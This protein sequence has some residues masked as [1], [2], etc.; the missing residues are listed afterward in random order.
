MEA[1]PFR[2]IEKVSPPLKGSFPLDYH[3]DCKL[4][5]LKYMICLNDNK[6]MNSE[7]RDQAKSY[8]SCRMEKGLMDKD[9]WKTLGFKDVD[10][11]KN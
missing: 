10:T 5:M 1:G 9:E 6:N 2:R 4:E 11:Q 3:G 7:C 8:F